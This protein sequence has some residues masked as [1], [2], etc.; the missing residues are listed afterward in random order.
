[1]LTIIRQLEEQI[2]RSEALKH[3]EGARN[4]SLGEVLREH[5]KDAEIKFDDNL[6]CGWIKPVG[7]NVDTENRAVIKYNEE[8]FHCIP[9]KGYYSFMKFMEGKI[10][11]HAVQLD[12][13][14]TRDRPAL[15]LEGVNVKNRAF[16]SF[17]YTEISNPIYMQYLL[18]SNG[19]NLLPGYHIN[20]PH[21]KGE[22]F[23]NTT[24]IAKGE[25]KGSLAQQDYIPESLYFLSNHLK[26]KK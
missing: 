7:Y 8:W 18:V 21:R 16:P 6:K 13:D 25:D 5:F 9:K 20:L 17:S 14:V 26:T 1:M 15:S 3:M 12:F 2:L 4:K 23:L 24:G 10:D 11:I 22:I 19:H